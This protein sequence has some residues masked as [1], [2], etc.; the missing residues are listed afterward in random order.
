MARVEK[1]PK[2]LERLQEIASKGFSPSSLTSYIRNPIDFYFQK[3][4]KIQEHQE[5][6][7][8]VA[9]NTLGTIVHDT[10][11]VLYTPFVSK[12]LSVAALESIYP[13]ISAEITAQFTKSFKGGDFS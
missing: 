8:T 2:I 12:V 10:L 7:E 9:A 6:E 4:L 3:V 13:K 1:T 5:V 11:E